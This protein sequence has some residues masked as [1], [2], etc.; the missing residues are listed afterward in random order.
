MSKKKKSKSNG[1]RWAT[2][3]NRTING[4]NTSE[5]TLIKA[6]LVSLHTDIENDIQTGEVDQK[7]AEIKLAEIMALWAKIG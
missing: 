7:T 6:G 5:L 3:K 4:L 1:P 2:E